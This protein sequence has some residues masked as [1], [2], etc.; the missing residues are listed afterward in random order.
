MAADQGDAIAEH[1]LG[2]AYYKGRG[3]EKNYGE[4][5]KWYRRSAEHGDADAAVEVGTAYQSGK[6][7]EKDYGEALKWFTKAAVVGHARGQNEVA[8]LLATCPESSYRNGATALD[9][10]RKAVAQSPQDNGTYQDTLAASYARNGQF[11]EAV[12]AQEKAVELIKANQ[13]SFTPEQVRGAELR[14]DLYKK[15]QPF[16]DE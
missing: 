13:Q 8:W 9:Y 15:G 3:V 6:G 14:L 1:S 5:V 11:N 12:P 16:T 4:S 10:A 7:I 2:N